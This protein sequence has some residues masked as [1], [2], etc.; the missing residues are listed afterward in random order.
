[1]WYD[2]W[3]K[4]RDLQVHDLNDYLSRLSFLLDNLKYT[5]PGFAIPKSVPTLF[6]FGQMQANE[7]VRVMKAGPPYNPQTMRF[8]NTAM[9]VCWPRPLPSCEVRRRSWR[10]TWP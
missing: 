7:I 1:M 5:S 9:A 4:T 6:G 8:P 2:A 10:L 3:S